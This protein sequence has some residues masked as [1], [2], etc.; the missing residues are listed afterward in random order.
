MPQKSPAIWGLTARSRS[1]PPPGREQHAGRRAQ[2]PAADGRPQQIEALEAEGGVGREAAEQ[3][4]HRE[5]AHISAEEPRA[6]FGN[7]NK[8][9]DEQTADQ[10]H[11]K[12]AVRKHLDRQAPLLPPG[13]AVPENRSDEATRANESDLDEGGSHLAKRRAAGR[14]ALFPILVPIRSGFS[15]LLAVDAQ[16]RPWN[17]LQARIGDLLA[18]FVALAVVAAF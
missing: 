12:R 2:P 7:T 9:A 15:L 16:D 4:N 3:A 18:A 5:Q 13:K 17:C 8:G 11:R 10:V 14:A 1:I 6:R